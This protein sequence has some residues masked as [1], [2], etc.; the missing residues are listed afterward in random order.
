[1]AQELVYDSQ[2]QSAKDWAFWL[3]LGHG[4]SVFFTLVAIEAWRLA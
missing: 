4:L 2:T 1:M 3:Y